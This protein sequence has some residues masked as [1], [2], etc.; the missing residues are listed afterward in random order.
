LVDQNVSLNKVSALSNL[1]G[2]ELAFQ[3]ENNMC[4]A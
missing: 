2:I 3:D 1:R 4:S